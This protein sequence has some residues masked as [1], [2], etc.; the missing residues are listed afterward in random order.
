[1]ADLLERVG[2]RRI[3]SSTF[4]RAQHSVAPLSRRSGLPIERDE[5]LVEAAL[6]EVNVPDWLDRLRATF[7]EPGLRFEGGESSQ[8][9][10]ARATA[11][12]GDVLGDYRGPT[13]VATHG[14]LLTLILR[15]FDSRF[16]FAEWQALT[17]P[18]AFKVVV[19]D[20]ASRVER[21]WYR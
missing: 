8:E 15:H 2:C 4:L 18:D 5:R 14:R 9:A 16:G 12:V 17:N 11:A 6:S 7:D 20:A 1:M 19:D 10:Q 21:I 13:V 3:V